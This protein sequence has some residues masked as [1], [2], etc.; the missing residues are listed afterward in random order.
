MNKKVQYLLFPKRCAFCDKVLDLGRYE[1]GSC[2]KCKN[3]IVYATEP[4]CKVCGKVIVDGNGELCHDCTKKKHYFVQSKGVYVYEGLVKGSMYRFK[5]G[6]RR[7]YKHTYVRDI[8]RMYGKWIKSLNIDAIIPI[9]MYIKKLRKRG[10][11]Q[12]QLVADALGREIN[13]PSYNNIVTRYR[14]TTP[15]K[16]LSDTQRQKNLK[17]AFNFSQKGLQLRRVLLIDDIYTTGTTMDCVARVLLDAG[18]KE[19][20]GLCMCVGKGYSH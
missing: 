4:V 7:G 11:N 6:N 13:V 2:R 16:G 1:Y 19:V 15:M 12:A 10:Y 9:P 8:V 5:Y 17:N 14:D 18:I 3:K 20:Y